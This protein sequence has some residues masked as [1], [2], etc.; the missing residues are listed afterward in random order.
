MKLQD[1]LGTSRSIAIAQIPSDRELAAQIQIRL[2][3]L[4]LLNPPADGLFGK[5]SEA[6]FKA[7]QIL[8]QMPQVGMLDAVT[9]EALI[10]TK[11]VPLKSTSVT[12]QLSLGLVQQIFFDAPTS[13]IKTYLPFVLNALDQ[14]KI[15]DREM[16]LM[17]LA[18][19]RAETAGFEPISEFQSLYNTPPGG[20]PFSLYDPGTPIGKDLGNTEPGDGAR[21][22][23]RGFI[24]L[25]GRYNYMIHSQ[26]I[27]LDDQL[28]KNPELAND[29]EIAARL[30]ASFLKDKELGI[31]KALAKFPPDYKSARR[32]VNGGSHGLDQFVAAFEAGD[33]LLM[34]TA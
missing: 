29:P 21:F 18:T 25:T 17:A 23:G 24:Q 1:F 12:Q 5:R 16:T 11:T 6:A 15:G 26:A 10:E 28:V 7:F 33:R 13:H 19:I 22:K 30:L 2:I 31:R 8:A 32:L 20:A 9:A 4:N 27:G 3:D 14:A 34:L